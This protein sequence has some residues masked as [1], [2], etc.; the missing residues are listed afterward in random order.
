MYQ[1]IVDLAQLVCIGVL[2]IAIVLH[3]KDKH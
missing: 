3:N 2:A 1:L